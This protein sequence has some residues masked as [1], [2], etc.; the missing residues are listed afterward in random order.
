M[1]TAHGQKFLKKLCSCHSI[2]FFFSLL[3]VQFFRW[4]AKSFFRNVLSFV[5]QVVCDQNPTYFTGHTKESFH[6]N[7]SLSCYLRHEWHTTCCV[8]TENNNGR[9]KWTYTV[10]DIPNLQK[11][12]CICRD[13]YIC[14]TTVPMATKL[15]W[16]VNYSERFPPIKSHEPLI[17]QSCEIPS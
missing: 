3:L 13:V 10:T 4:T 6:K 14:T 12:N 7:C 2:F 16:V 8:L 11:N 5:T 15:I 1:Y 9:S 17:T